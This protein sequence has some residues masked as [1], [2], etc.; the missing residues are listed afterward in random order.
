[1]R[2]AFA[3]ATTS[4]AS[5]VVDYIH[6]Q[7]EEFGLDGLIM[8]GCQRARSVDYGER[9]QVLGF[10]FID[11]LEK[12]PIVSCASRSRQPPAVGPWPWPWPWPWLRGREVLHET[13][14]I[15]SRHR[16]EAGKPYEPVAR[17]AL[18]CIEIA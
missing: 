18:I 16:D 11:C 2:T 10:G 9:S 14:K 17:S 8:V 12:N 1:V 5:R 13:A 7:S 4:N 15:G 6:G 3:D